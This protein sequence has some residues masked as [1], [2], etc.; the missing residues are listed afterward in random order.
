MLRLTEE[1][2][3]SDGWQWSD[4]QVILLL[5]NASLGLLLFEWA[6]H[7]SRRFRTPIADLDTLM[8][9][10][11]RTD[12]HKWRK[13]AFYPGAVTIL[14]PRFFFGVFDVLFLILFVKFILIG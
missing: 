3:A 10:F 5:V 8:P 7:S 4:W 13:W 2:E 11:R 1:L 9:A 6:W 14:I 12:A